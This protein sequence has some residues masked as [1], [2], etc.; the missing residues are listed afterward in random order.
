MEINCQKT[1]QKVTH[2]LKRRID[3]DVKNQFLNAIRK[4]IRR[5]CKEVSIGNST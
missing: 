3:N 4:G 1:K 2:H 5:I